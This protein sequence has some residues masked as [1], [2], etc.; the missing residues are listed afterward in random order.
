MKK[1]TA[2]LLVLACM[3]GLAGCNHQ[4]VQNVKLLKEGNVTD[5]TVT[6]LPERYEYSFSG[7]D[8]KAIVAYLLALRRG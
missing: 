4:P 1:I 8:V 3:W 2:L 5:I 6:S 7:E